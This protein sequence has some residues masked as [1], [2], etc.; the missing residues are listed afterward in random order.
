MDK[1]YSSSCTPL[2][3]FIRNRIKGSAFS[4]VLNENL[5]NQFEAT[6]P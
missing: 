4:R 2:N 1:K 3:K 5:N 6:L